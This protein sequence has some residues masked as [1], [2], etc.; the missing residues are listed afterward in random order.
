[1]CAQCY[2]ARVRQICSNDDMITEYTQLFANGYKGVDEVEAEFNAA[3]GESFEYMDPTMTNLM[4]A[5]E[6]T[7]F[8]G[9]DLS[10]RQ[11]ICSSHAFATAMT[12]DMVCSR[13]ANPPPLC[14]LS[15]IRVCV[16]RS[17]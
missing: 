3:F 1:M 12:L 10:K 7:S 14:T 11:D 2:Y 8:S 9:P 5:V 13:L 15:A 17:S 6:V 16:R 4:R